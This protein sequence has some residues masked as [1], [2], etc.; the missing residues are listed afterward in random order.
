MSGIGGRGT[1]VHLYINGLYWGLY[2]VTERTDDA[3]ASNYLGGKEEEHYCRKAKGGT[4]DG[5]ST[6]FHHWE[7]TVV[8]SGDFVELENYLSDLLGIKVDLVE[9][10]TLKPRIGKRVLGEIVYPW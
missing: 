7:N 8:N 9:K 5:D 4:V 3:H 10:S 6:R 2:N 1:W